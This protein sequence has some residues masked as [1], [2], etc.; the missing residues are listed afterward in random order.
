MSEGDRS[1]IDM[2]V[3]DDS[4]VATEAVVA[5]SNDGGVHGC[6]PE[7]NKEEEFILKSIQSSTNTNVLVKHSKC[8]I[9]ENLIGNLPSFSSTGKLRAPLRS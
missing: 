1:G 8:T 3:L 9:S 4:V 6:R 2:D 5:S 7:K